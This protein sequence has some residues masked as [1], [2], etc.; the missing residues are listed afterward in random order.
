MSIIGL[1]VFGLLM[2]SYFDPKERQK[3]KSWLFGLFGVSF[4]IPL[5]HILILEYLGQTNDSM[6]LSNFAQRIIIFGGVYL[7]GLFIY[8]VQCP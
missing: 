2:S 7:V 5:A 8:T 4:I 6:T 3:Q 1:T